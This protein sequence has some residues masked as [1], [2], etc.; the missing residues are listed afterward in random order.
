[1]GALFSS[2]IQ[3]HSRLTSL[4]NIP[5]LSPFLKFLAQAQPGAAGLEPDYIKGGGGV[6]VPLEE[7]VPVVPA[8]I[9]KSPNICGNMEERWGAPAMASVYMGIITRLL[10]PAWTKLMPHQDHYCFPTATGDIL[11]NGNLVS[12]ERANLQQFFLVDHTSCNTLFCVVKT[13]FW[14][15]LAVVN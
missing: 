1:M 4:G 10:L 11:V 14:G 9:Q 2:P 3:P 15:T 7:L 6:V 8:E 13:V 12:L 5:F